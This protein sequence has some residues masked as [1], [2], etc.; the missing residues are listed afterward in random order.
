MCKNKACCRQPREYKKD[1]ASNQ[2]IKELP[3][4]EVEKGKNA[5]PAPWVT[6]P[7]AQTSHPHLAQGQCSTRRR[8]QAAAAA[9]PYPLHRPARWQRCERT[10]T[11][12][13]QVASEHQRH[14]EPRATHRWLLRLNISLSGVFCS[15]CV[16]FA[17][18]VMAYR[19]RR[20]PLFGYDGSLCIGN[21]P[22]S[23]YKSAPIKVGNS[24][25][26]SF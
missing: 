11:G 1:D 9:P 14:R 15:L 3:V 8:S 7:V 10:S 6:H 4:C 12:Q 24:P 5:I 13:N 20:A 25:L 22:P 23:S 17:A 16:R 2:T 26:I 21:A 18:T 19:L